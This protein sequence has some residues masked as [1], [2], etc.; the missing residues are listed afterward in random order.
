MGMIA[1]AQTVHQF[2]RP[3]DD[4]DEFVKTFEED[5]RRHMDTLKAERK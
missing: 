5:R 2:Y 3:L 1:G 4:L